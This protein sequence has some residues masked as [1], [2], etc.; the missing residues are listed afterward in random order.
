MNLRVGK[1]L[2]A[3][4]LYLLCTLTHGDEA[5]K[6]QEV[7]TLVKSAVRYAKDKGRDKAL[8]EFVNPNGPFIKGELYLFVYDKH[9]VALA[10]INDK[11]IGKNMLNMRDADGVY[12]IK[13]VLDIG[14]SKSGRGWQTY[15]WPNP[16]TKDVGVKRSYTEYYDGL[17][18]SSGYYR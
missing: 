1:A 12:L 16:V 7:V 6:A 8:R 3:A 2:A 13:K 9:G 10:H 14:N 18:I 4:F 11:M 5:A 15:K 17:Y